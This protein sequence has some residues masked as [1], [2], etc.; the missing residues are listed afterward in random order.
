MKRRVSYPTVTSRERAY[1]G[2]CRQKE[3]AGASH[4]AQQ[5]MSQPTAPKLAPAAAQDSTH[6]LLTEH[7]RGCCQGAPALAAWHPDERERGARTDAWHLMHL[8]L[9][10]LHHEVCR[11]PRELLWGLR[12]GNRC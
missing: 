12:G 7:S 4:Q 5:Q 10:L 8:R 2:G 6:T 11:A 9:P 3:F 1:P